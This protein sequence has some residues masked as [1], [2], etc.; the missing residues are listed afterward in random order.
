MGNLAYGNSNAFEALLQAF[1][2]KN[3]SVAPIQDIK[4]IFSNFEQIRTYHDQDFLQL[5]FCEK[6]QENAAKYRKFFAP[7]LNFL[8]INKSMCGIHPNIYCD[9]AIFNSSS[10]SPAVSHVSSLLA[11]KYRKTNGAHYQSIDCTKYELMRLCFSYSRSHSACE[12]K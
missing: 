5:N 10:L 6:F 4:K 9:T 2:D 12:F 1:A 3:G 8:N 7:K 11:N